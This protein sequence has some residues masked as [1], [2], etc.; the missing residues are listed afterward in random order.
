MNRTQVE[1]ASGRA[2]AAIRPAC[3]ADL[4]ALRDFFAALSPQTRYLRFFAPVT[5][6]PALLD[7]LSGGAAPPTPW[8][9]PAAASSS[10]T[11]WQ[12]TGTGPLR[13]PDDRYRRGGGR[14]LA[15]PGRGI[16][17]GARPDHQRPGARRDVGGDGCAAGNHRVLAMIKGHWPASAHRLFPGLRHHLRPASGG[18]QHRPQIP[19]AC[20]G[21]R[22]SAAHTDEPL[23]DPGGGVEEGGGGPGGRHPP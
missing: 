2:A 19:S 11:P 5:P 18:Q 13:R 20:P 4:P 21:T 15:G 16:G 8:S 9:P 17:A 14:R 1:R 12:R 6:G 23:A 3:P 7:L 10:G 22:Q